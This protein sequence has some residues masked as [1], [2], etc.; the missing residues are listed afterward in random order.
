MSL[1]KLNTCPVSCNSWIATKGNRIFETYSKQQAQAAQDA[2]WKV[3]TVY[4]H[5]IDLNADK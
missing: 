4:K 3:K 5:L 2:G 1:P